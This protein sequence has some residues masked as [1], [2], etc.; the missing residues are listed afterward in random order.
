MMSFDMFKTCIDKIPSDVAIHF[1][2]FSE[3]WLNPQCEKMVLYAHEKNHP[4]EVYTT[5]V[6]MRLSNI[7][8]LE[9]IPLRRF[10]VHL[11]SSENYEKIRVDQNYL[12]LLKR[13]SKIKSNIVYQFYGKNLHPQVKAIV[14]NAFPAALCTRAGNIKIA[15]AISIPQ[16]KGGIECSQDINQHANVLLPNG[17]VVLCSMDFGM[18]HQLGNLA[19]SDYASLFQGKEFLKVRQGLKDEA[20]DSLCRFCEFSYPAGLLRILGLGKLYC[21]M[22]NARSLGGFIQFMCKVIHV[23]IRKA[24]YFIRGKQ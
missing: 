7:D 18:Q 17:D 19:F 11:P 15:G 9:R 21:R 24:Y 10:V 4:I 13:L 16:K 22:K 1:S 20:A 23:E 5:L 8:T 2:G 3:P 12:D 6:G 14:K